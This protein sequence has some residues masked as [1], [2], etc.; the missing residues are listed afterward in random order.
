MKTFSGFAS[1][2]SKQVSFP[3]QFFTELLPLID[4]LVELKVTLA[5]F[6]LFDQ[7]T[8]LLKWATVKGLESDPALKDIQANINVGLEKA[9][10]R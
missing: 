3:D 1:S 4:D 5:C 10:E 8:G 9:V 2:S 6:W 7:K